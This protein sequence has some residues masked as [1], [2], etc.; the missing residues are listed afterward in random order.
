[1]TKM[2]TIVHLGFFRFFLLACRLTDH[3]R[4]HGEPVLGIPL[5]ITRYPGHIP[6]EV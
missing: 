3:D 6:T 2:P 1:M 5:S 4:L